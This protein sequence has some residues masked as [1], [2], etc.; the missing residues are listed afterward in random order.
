MEKRL[1]MPL[2]GFIEKLLLGSSQPW[3]ACV[4]SHGPNREADFISALPKA[5]MRTHHDADTIRK[6][7]VC[8]LRV[9]V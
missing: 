6:R 7:M 5:M 2:T 9:S 1:S 3:A 8:K 4:A